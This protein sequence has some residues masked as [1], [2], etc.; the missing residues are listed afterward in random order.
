MSDTSESGRIATD[1][2]KEQ[3]TKHEN[4]CEHCQRSG[5]SVS[6]GSG[7]KGSEPARGLQPSVK[8][9]IQEV[10]VGR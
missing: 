10:D 3:L 7:V 9:D 6:S 1:L 4:E 2:T 8:S 5:T